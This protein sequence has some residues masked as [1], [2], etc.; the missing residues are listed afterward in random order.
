[1]KNIEE[2]LLDNC[3]PEPN[4]GCW[5]WTASTSTGG[6]GQIR[7]GGKKRG[8]H[9]V[10]YETWVGSI[11]EGLCVCHK[12]DVRDCINPEHLFLGTYKDNVRDMMKKGRIAVGNRHGSRTHPESVL[13]GEKQWNVKLTEGKVL[14]IRSRIGERQIDLAQE[15]GVSRPVIS[16]ILNKRIWAHV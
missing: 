6:Y 5:L 1:M 11:P 15:F 7:V 12:C 8:T 2:R 4:S 10:A 9:R 16:R 3:I 14:E 13:R